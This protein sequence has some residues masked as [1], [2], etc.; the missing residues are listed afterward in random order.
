MDWRRVTTHT[1][2]LLAMLLIVLVAPRAIV[3]FR[4][5]PDIAPQTARLP[6]ADAAIIFGAHLRNDGTPTEILKTDLT[7]GRLPAD[8]LG[9]YAM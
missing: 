6:H 9:M 3:A 2:V 7:L 1:P 4:F 8:L 5:A